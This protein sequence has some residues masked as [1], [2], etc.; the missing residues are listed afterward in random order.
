MLHFLGISIY[1]I[2]DF[3]LHNRFF[4]KA[5]ESKTILTDINNQHTDHNT[6]EE[7]SNDN[8]SFKGGGDFTD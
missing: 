5:N 2:L 8:G 6:K 3:T 7:V 4:F 1:S